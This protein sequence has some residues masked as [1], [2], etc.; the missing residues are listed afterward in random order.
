VLEILD[1]WDYLA[2]IGFNEKTVFER[3]LKREIEDME[4]TDRAQNIDQWRTLLNTEMSLQ[5][6]LERDF[7]ESLSN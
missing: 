5:I 2:S 7:S 3:A 1:L 6:S 4:W